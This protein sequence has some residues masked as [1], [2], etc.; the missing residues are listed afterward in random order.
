PRL[1][2]LLRHRLALYQERDARQVLLR[3][4][5]ARVRLLEITLGAVELRLVGARID[6]EQEVAL[7][8]QRALAEWHQFEVATDARAHLDR[9]HRL[10]SRGVLVPVG[11][12]A[13][14]RM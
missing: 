3:E 4:V 1:R 13:L 11:Q 7:L 9:V 14:D 8:D 6:L 10:E 5:D 2:F 12:I